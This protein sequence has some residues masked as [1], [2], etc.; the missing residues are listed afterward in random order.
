MLRSSKVKSILVELIPEH[1]NQY[2]RS[3]KILKNSGFKLSE[4]HDFNHIF[5]K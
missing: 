4:K 2:D 1:K 5:V 3:L